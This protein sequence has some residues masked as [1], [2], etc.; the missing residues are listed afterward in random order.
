M[1]K[2]IRTSRTAG[3]LEK[4]FR[5][6]NAHFFN[7]ELPE[8]IISL[9]KTVG[10]YG[11]F[12]V[13]KVWQAGEERRY[14]INVSSATLNRPIEEVCSTLLHEMCHEF[15]TE[16]NIKD[17]SGGGNSYHNKR[18]KAIAESHGLEVAHHEKYGWTITTPGIEL[19]EFIE[20]QGWQ[21]LQMVEGVS[22]WDVLGTLPGGA[23]QPGTGAGTDGRRPSSTR[24]LICPCCGQSVRATRAVN[25][26]CGDCM[27][28]MVEA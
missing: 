3:Q 23:A 15:A 20:S 24:K 5:A 2:T 27:L 17:T 14:E 6:L 7:D 22:L 13:D 9:K 16:Q 4:M 10:A 19:L 12:T 21:D 25:I 11:H 18:F 8:A 26:L 28:R 1:K